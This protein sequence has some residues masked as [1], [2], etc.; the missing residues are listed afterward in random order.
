MSRGRLS[1]AVALLLAWAGTATPAGDPSQAGAYCPFPEKGE[2][3]VCFEKVES[4]YSDF[5]AA[6]DSGEIHS[7]SV[8]DVELALQGRTAGAD[9]ALALSSLAYGYY[10]LAERAASETRPDP[11]LVS[12]LERWN[13]LLGSVYEGA[14]Q[15]PEL[16]SAVREAALD[17]HARA[18]AVDCAEGDDACSTTGILLRTLR[19]IDDPAGESSGVRGALGKLLGR[20]MDSEEDASGGDAGTRVDAE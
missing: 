18:P 20:M 8:D 13:E 1:L 14:G 12:R 6:V 16:R 7:A 5:F 17:L 2:K 9:R 11:A 19:G 10:M 15:E 3:P 4:E